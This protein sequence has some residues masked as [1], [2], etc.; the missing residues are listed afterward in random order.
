[1]APWLHLVE[2]FLVQQL[3]RTPA[4]H[5]GVEK[6]AKTV[7]R[8]RHGTPAEEMGGTKIDQPSQSGYVQHF[9]DELKT[10]LGNETKSINGGSG[11]AGVNMDSRAMGHGGVKSKVEQQAA[12][13]DAVNAEA[14]WRDAQQ[15][16]MQ[17]KQ[18]GFLSEY[19]NALRQQM[20]G[21]KKS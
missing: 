4:F 1:M 20:K 17:P 18:Q 21:D 7:H 14:A 15:N 11:Q 5:R 9:L 12:E 10:Q 16:A 3:L 6:V 13:V 19:S 2:A 8:V